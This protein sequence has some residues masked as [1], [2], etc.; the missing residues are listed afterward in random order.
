MYQV[1]AKSHTHTRSQMKSVH[2][3]W[4]VVDVDSVWWYVMYCE[5][6]IILSPAQGWG[7]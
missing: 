3:D 6:D 2:V 5:N 1:V 7:V 4:I